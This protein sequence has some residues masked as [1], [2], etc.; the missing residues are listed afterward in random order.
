MDYIDLAY[1]FSS[2]KMKATAHW[3]FLENFRAMVEKYLRAPS[4]NIRIIPLNTYCL[5]LIT[6]AKQYMSKK[7]CPRRIKRLEFW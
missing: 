5:S 4:Q 3:P 7:V 1:T 6:S 2:R